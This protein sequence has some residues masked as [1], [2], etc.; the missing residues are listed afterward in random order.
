MASTDD[1]ALTYDYYEYKF[2]VNVEWQEDLMASVDVTENFGFTNR[3]LQLF[4]N[5]SEPVVCWNSCSNCE[6]TGAI[7]GCTDPAASNYAATAT[8]DDGSCQYA[9]TFQVDMAGY[10]GAYGMV[11]LNGS[12]TGWCGSCVVMDDT[13]G[14]GVYAVTVDVLAEP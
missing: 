11:N 6:G 5:Q 12:F 14:D 10:S 4:G 2:T 7:F 9:I 1:Q 8:D 13:D 3:V